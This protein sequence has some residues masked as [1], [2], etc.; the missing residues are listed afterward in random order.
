MAYY[1]RRDA[2][3]SNWVG[4]RG[5]VWVTPSAIDPLGT[6][7]FVKCAKHLKLVPV[8]ESLDLNA[9]IYEAFDRCPGCID[10]KQALKSRWPEGAEL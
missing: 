2:S 10:E 4:R 1:N 8:A 6:R 3:D 9:A 7:H 5:T